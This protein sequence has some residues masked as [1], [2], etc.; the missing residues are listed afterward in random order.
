[1]KNVG[2]KDRLISTL[3]FFELNFLK[4]VFF[5]HRS[6]SIHSRFD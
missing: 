5:K 1:M 6:S 4:L 3:I 2:V